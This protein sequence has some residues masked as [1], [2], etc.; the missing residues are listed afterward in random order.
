MCPQCTPASVGPV[1]ATDKWY[2]R[3]EKL[4]P[5]C[6]VE[7][8]R[9]VFDANPLHAVAQAGASAK[10]AG[11]FANATPQKLSQLLPQTPS[12]AGPA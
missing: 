9:A 6:T 1:A 4:F 10:T 12:P 11:H 7:L 3:H 2:S 5:D 8:K